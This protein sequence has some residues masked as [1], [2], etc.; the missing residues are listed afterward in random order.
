MSISYEQV[1]TDVLELLNKV[2]EDWEYSETITP[3][4]G[5]LSDLGFESLELVIL[6]VSIQDHYGQII[7]FPEFLADLGER[8]VPDIFVGDLVEFVRQH[9]NDRTVGAT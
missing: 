2:S 8:K 3:D 4:T 7:P 5:L 9:L 1:K 6:G